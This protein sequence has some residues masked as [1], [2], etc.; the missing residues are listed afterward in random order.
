MGGTLIAEVRCDPDA[1]F[2]QF[3]SRILAALRREDPTVTAAWFS[4]RGFTLGVRTFACDDDY[5][6]LLGAEPLRTLAAAVAA[7]PE[8]SIPCTVILFDDPHSYA[9]AAA[10]W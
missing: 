7:H 3:K 5:F 9:V 10:R 6:R 1:T 8:S 4:L 2:G